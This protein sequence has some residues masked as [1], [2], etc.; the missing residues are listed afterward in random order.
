MKLWCCTSSNN[1]LKH[2][3]QLSSSLH[4]FIY[5][6]AKKKGQRKRETRFLH[7]Q[8]ISWKWVET[9][10]RQWGRKKGRKKEK[11]KRMSDA[12]S[13][14]PRRGWYARIIITRRAARVSNK[15]INIYDGVM[16]C[17]TW[18][19][20][21]CAGLDVCVSS[22]LF[23]F[24]VI[25]MI[26]LHLWERREAE[27]LSLIL[28]P[29]LFI[30]FDVASPTSFPVCVHRGQVHYYYCDHYQDAARLVCK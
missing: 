20:L 2:F 8:W 19:A 5:S 6:S 24:K 27:T 10:S 16:R 21:C 9:T 7:C 3:I 25:F 13:R 23:I 11:G 12:A 18:V 4:H 14:R 29:L 30:S 22:S 26:L 17:P 15:I 28:W 1:W